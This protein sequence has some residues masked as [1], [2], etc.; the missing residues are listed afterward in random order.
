M[1]GAADPIRVPRWNAIPS[2]AGPFPRTMRRASATRPRAGIPNAACSARADD[3]RR[4]SRYR[5]DAPSALA[6]AEQGLRV[7]RPV[8]SDERSGRE[9]A[10]EGTGR[11]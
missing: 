4:R 10:V 1:N 3:G 6:R 11:R 2:G 7:L 8:H 5:G 9:R